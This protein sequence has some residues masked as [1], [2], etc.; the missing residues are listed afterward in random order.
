MNIKGPPKPQSVKE[1]WSFTKDAFLDIEI[2]SEAV[3]MFVEYVFL[4]EQKGPPQT[5]NVNE[6]KA[7]ECE[8]G[9]EHLKVHGL[10]KGRAAN[11]FT[12]SPSI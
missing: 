3:W 11:W 12:P 5:P 7:V 8:I 9:C 2:T 6:E 1:F 4:Q 10:D